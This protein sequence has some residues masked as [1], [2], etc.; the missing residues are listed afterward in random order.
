MRKLLTVFFAALLVFSGFGGKVAAK[1]AGNFW[2]KDSA[3]LSKIENYV[4]TVSKKKGRDY[5]APADRIAVFDLDGTIFCETFPRPFDWLMLTDFVN[6]RGIRT[7]LEARNTAKEINE[8]IRLDAPFDMDVRVRKAA[9][10]AY[11]SLTFDE[12]KDRAAAVKKTKAVGFSDMTKGDAFY[13]P[14]TELINYLR[15]NDFTVYI[16]CDTEETAARELVCDKLNIPPQNVIGTSCSTVATGQ[17]DTP[18][19]T[20]SLRASDKITVGKD[21]TVN[22]KMNKVNAIMNRIGKRPVLAFG[23]S[24]NDSCMLTFVQANNPHKSLSFVVLNDD[25]TRD[26]INETETDEMRQAATFNGWHTVSVKK[27]FAVLYGKDVK[28]VRTLP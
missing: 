14:M 11:R 13:L 4:E 19:E 22:I 15:D 24:L 5:I 7:P 3:A 16:V 26:Y 6:E 20:Y 28:K 27:D 23:N 1:D 25:D 2:T 8:T 12:L 17:N 9:A 18:A 21:V 10:E